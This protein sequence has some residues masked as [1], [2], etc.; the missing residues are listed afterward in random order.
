MKYSLYIDKYND[1]LVLERMAPKNTVSSYV[2]DVSQFADYLIFDGRDDFTTVNEDDIRTYVS[3]LQEQGRSQATVSRCVASLKSFFNHMLSIGFLT[4]NPASNIS[5]SY[6]AKK[7]PQTLSGHQINRL[8]DQP[9][10]SDLK[11][12]RDKAMLELLYAT[13]IRV[14]ELVALNETDIKI[15]S[16]IITCGGNKE[17]VIPIYDKAQKVLAR[18]LTDTRPKIA[19]AGEVALFVNIGGVR[20]SRQGFW[21]IL[22]TL[23]EKAQI[24]VDITPSVLRHSFAAHLL[25]NGADLRSL[26]EMLGHADISSTQVYARALKKG[27]KD[28]YNKTHPRA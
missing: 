13:G 16:G 19:A 10:I 3:R 2:R 28:V 22:K 21:K 15:S 27:L 24:D 7:T 1:Y 6:A 8:L 12:C 4:S 18:Y 25:N 20:M 14:S 5:V 9:D 17:R 23:A 26:Q 11:G